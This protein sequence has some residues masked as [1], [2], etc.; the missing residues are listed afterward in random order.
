MR[1]HR[2]LAWVL[3]GALALVG[4]SDSP[5]SAGDDDDMLEHY[6]QFVDA[7]EQVGVQL[8]PPRRS[9]GTPRQRPPRHARRARP[10]LAPTLGEPQ[11]KQFRS[12]S[13][14]RFTGIG[15]SGRFRPPHPAAPTSSPPRS[16]PPP[17][18]PASSPA[19]WS[20]KSTASP[21]R[22]HP[23]PVVEALTGRPG[24]QVT[25]KVKHP[26]EDEPEMLT[27]TR[28]I[29]EV[30][31]VIGDTASPTTTPG[32]SCSIRRQ[33]SAT[34]A[35]PPSA[36]T[37][38]PTSTRPSTNSRTQDVKGL[39]LDLRDDPG[40]L[41]SAAVQ[42]CDDFL[43]DGTIV[44]TK[45]RNY[46]ERSPTTPKAKRHLRGRPHGRPHQ[47]P[48]RH[49]LRDRRVRPPGS[50]SAPPSSVSGAGARAPSRAS[51][52]SKKAR[53]IR[54]TVATYHRPSGVP[55]HRFQNAK[56]ASEA[57][58]V[59]PDP[60]GRSSSPRRITSG[61]EPAASATCSPANPAPARR[62]RRQ[63]SR[64]ASTT[65]SSTRRSTPSPK[66]SPGPPQ[67]GEKRRRVMSHTPAA[68]P[69][70]SAPLRLLALETTCDETGA[71]VL[72]TRA[73]RGSF[74]VP[75]PLQCRRLADSTSTN[76]S[77]A[78]SPKSP[79]APTSATSSP[80]STSPSARRASA[81]RDLDAVAVAT[82]PGLVGSLVVGLTAAK[83]LAL[84]LEIPLVAVDHLEGHLYACQMAHPDRS[85]YPCVGLVVSGGHIQSLST[86]G[87][88]STPRLL[89]GTIDDA[90]GEAF[91]KVASLLG[92]PYP[93]G[94]AIDQAAAAGN[95]TRLSPSPAPSC[96]TPASTSASPASRPPSST[97]S[98]ARTPEPS[99]L[100][101]H[102]RAHRRPR[103]QLPG[104]PS[105]TSSSP[106]P[107]SPCDRP[108]SRRLGVGGGVAANTALREA[109]AAMATPR[110][111]SCSSPLSPL[112]RQRRHGR[113][114]LRQARR[115]PDRP[116]R[117]RRP[118]R[119]HPPGQVVGP[120]SPADAPATSKA[121]EPTRETRAAA[122]PIPAAA[123]APAAGSPARPR[124]GS[125]HHWSKAE[126]AAPD[127]SS[128][129]RRFVKAE[130]T[131]PQSYY[132]PV[133]TAQTRHNR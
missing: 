4:V 122:G 131:P 5:G 8:R 108:D 121:R 33:E 53:A 28:A 116:P 7:V 36:T 79:P 72:E 94:P 14:A 104:R 61:P 1:G 107:A 117:L 40:G 58:G 119:P 95:P 34:S 15:V 6:G 24:T 128:P 37:P 56:P 69:P 23:R 64:R 25:L 80:S 10:L 129:P 100:A 50:R 13:R 109:L 115:R 71:A 90:A 22:T 59:S 44:S 99:P 46:P 113:H 81:S 126:V 102:P 2:G 16:A 57:W 32:T 92:L 66:R 130:R 110:G 86:A 52:P 3:V 76:D 103:R 26:D 98:A 42:V 124:G 91:D 11:W 60:D 48:L 77:A 127:A 43:P 51:S 96:T 39:I 27:I 83:S 38:P 101:P 55:I 54:L 35:S 41:L 68:L 132:H 9:Q 65:P 29:I 84:A 19:T 67:G 120:L 17:T 12:R 85:A 123:G 45:G 74:A 133:R 111:S 62:G 97:P 70:S 87:A 93:G 125:K 114:R 78:S 112:H 21:P 88:A 47:Q 18:P 118:A 63:G 49:R 73:A 20:S 89:G 106:R 31:T 30:D 105:S 82:R 75:H